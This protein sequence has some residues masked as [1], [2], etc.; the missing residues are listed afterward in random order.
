MLI[1]FGTVIAIFIALL[2]SC[3]V[4]VFNVKQ[5]AEQKKEITRLQVA[6]RTERRKNR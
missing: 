1:D 6:L 3:F 2:T 4:M 5:N